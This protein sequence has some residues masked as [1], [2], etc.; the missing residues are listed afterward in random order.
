MGDATSMGSGGANINS[1]ANQTSHF[2]S[3]AQLDGG[4]NTAGRE[5]PNSKIPGK[6]SK[7]RVNSM[8]MGNNTLY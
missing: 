8:A 2:K 1:I 3:L 6:I 5:S 7:T 4:L